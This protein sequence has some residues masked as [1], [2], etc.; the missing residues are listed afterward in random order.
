MDE[1]SQPSQIPCLPHCHAVRSPGAPADRE[2]WLRFP[3]CK[4][5]RAPA[6]GELRLH[7]TVQRPSW[8]LGRAFGQLNASGRPQVNL[9]VL[10]LP[11]TPGF[12]KLSSFHCLFFLS[13]CS[14]SLNRKILTPTFTPHIQ[15]LKASQTKTKGTSAKFVIHLWDFCPSIVI[16]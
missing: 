13:L 12:T 6:P 11:T 15:C 16:V 4:E 8:G 14:V 2:L 1:K 5:P 10:L 3:P 7:H 9:K